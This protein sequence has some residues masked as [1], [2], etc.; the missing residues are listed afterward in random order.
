MAFGCL[1]TVAF[2]IALG[3]LLLPNGPL[4]ALLAVGLSVVVVLMGR[5]LNSEWPVL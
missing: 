1:A 4:V 3:L 5:W 2:W